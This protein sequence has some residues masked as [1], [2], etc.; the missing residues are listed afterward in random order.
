MICLPTDYQQQGSLW[1]VTYRKFAQE[2]PVND[3]HAAFLLY[4]EMA[5]VTPVLLVSM[6]IWAAFV[7]AP[8]TRIAFMSV[9][10]IVEGLVVIL[11]ARNQAR[12]WYRTCWRSPLQICTGHASCV[13]KRRTAKQPRKRQGRHLLI[14]H[15]Q[16]LREKK[17]SCL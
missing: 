12:D 2:T 16:A 4:R 6:M 1:F 13:S 15:M 3:A 11:A 8:W 7:H 17:I 14:R 5:A 10:V 9:S